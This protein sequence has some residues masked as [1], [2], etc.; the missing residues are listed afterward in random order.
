MPGWI[1]SAWTYGVLE[2]L[3]AAGLIWYFRS[4]KRWQQAPPSHDPESQQAEARL[5]ST[6]TMDQG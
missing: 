6:H 5:W 1:T 3:V 4:F 2:V